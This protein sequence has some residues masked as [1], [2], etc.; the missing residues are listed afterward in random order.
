MEQ[1]SPHLDAVV[2][3]LV[4]H[5]GVGLYAC[6]CARPPTGIEVLREFSGSRVP[7]AIKVNRWRV[8]VGHFNPIQEGVE[9][10]VLCACNQFVA[11][12]PLFEARPWTTPTSISSWPWLAA[13]LARSRRRGRRRMECS[14]RRSARRTQCWGLRQTPCGGHAGAL[15]GSGAEGVGGSSAAGG[16]QCAVYLRMALFTELLYPIAQ[17]ISLK[18]QDMHAAS[19]AARTMQR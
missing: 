5:C 3:R 9:A 10:L 16:A 11:V 14:S 12:A 13:S 18:A 1:P 15:A 6:L 19:M 8:G 2:V 17:L 7:A 4:V